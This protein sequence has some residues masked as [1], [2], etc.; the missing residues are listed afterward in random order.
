MA[1]RLVLVTGA[2]TLCSSFSAR[3]CDDP[4]ADAK[5]ADKI[6]SVDIGISAA[7]LDDMIKKGVSLLLEKQEGETKAEWPYEGVYRVGGRIPIGYRVGGTAIVATALLEAP[8]YSEDDAR[9]QA[10]KR[11]I[12]FIVKAADDPLMSPDY[13]GGYDVRGWGYTYGLSFL[14]RLKQ[15][16]A[17]PDGLAAAVEDLIKVDI[18]AIQMTPIPQVGGWN[19]ARGAGKDKVSPPSPFMTAPTLQALLEAKAAGYLIDE[20]VFAKAIETL[21]KS[22]T[23][24][25]GVVYSGNATERS[26][27]AV[28]GAVGRMLVTETTLLKAGKGSVA[29]VR[30]AIDAFIVH[31]SWLDQRRAK[32]GT[33]EGPYQI[34]PYYFYYAHRYCAQAIEML[35]VNERNE[36]RRRLRMLLLSVRLEDGSWNDRVFP[37]S[38]AFGTAFCVISLVE[39]SK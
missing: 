6:Q 21:E 29:Q 14:L 5:R 2:L 39:M 20:G 12:E 26:R 8:G 35:P 31:W 32:K 22:R 18:N 3:A 28:P 30:S 4:P 27:D 10:V 19:Y 23:A 33:H 17:I 16:N 11:A 25:G 15:L 7:L 36:Y 13:D 37:R 38:S 1:T 34:A 24:A 9:K